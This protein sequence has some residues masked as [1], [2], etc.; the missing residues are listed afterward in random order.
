MSETVYLTTPLTTEAVSNLRITDIVYLSGT[1]YTARD[2][3]HQKIREL[4]DRKE[5]LPESFNGAAV[6]HAGPVVRKTT[7][8]YDLLLIGP[9]TSIRMEPFSDMHGK[10]GT[11]AIIGKGGLGNDSSL[12]FKK[13]GMVYLLAAGGCGSLHAQAVKRVKKVHW[14]EMGM[15]EAIWVLQVEKWGPLTVTMDSHGNSIH[16]DIEQEGRKKID[17]LVQQMA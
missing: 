16:R 2:M 11:K 14:I 9:T 8:G 15:P 10:L 13:Y 17:A 12:A 7:V 6:Y 3:A 4:V 5:P 1:I